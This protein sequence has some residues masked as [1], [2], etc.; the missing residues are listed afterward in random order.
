MNSEQPIELPDG[1]PPVESFDYDLLPPSLRPWIEDVCE[2]MQCPPDFAAVTAIVALGAVI[3]QKITIRPQQRTDWT[4]T[5]NQWGLCIGRP[6]TMK[7]P[8]QQ[9]M[10]SPLDLLESKAKDEY[11]Q[12]MKQHQAKLTEI[13]LRKEAAT[14]VMKKAFRRNPNAETP[15][16]SIQI[17]DPE[18]PCFRRYRII[19]SSVQ[20]LAE[21]HRKAPNG[22][23]VYRDEI[24][25]LLKTLDRDDRA[26][27]RGFYLTGWNGNSPWITD[28][29]GRGMNLRIDSVCLS[30][31]GGTQPAKIQKYAHEAIHGGTGDDGLIQR[32]GLM[33][34]PDIHGEWRNIDREPDHD[35]K[36]RAFK[37]FESLDTLEPA[38]HG[39]QYDHDS[40][41]QPINPPYLRFAP[42]AAELFLEWRTD[43]EN[44]LRNDG[45]HPAMESHLAK[46]RKHIPGLALIL[47]LANGNNGPVSEPPL[48]QALAWGDYLESHAKR[49]YS[50]CTQLEIDAAKA[51]LRLLR[52]KTISSPVSARDIYHMGRHQLSNQDIVKAALELLASR[53]WL[54]GEQKSTGGRPTIVYHAR[55]E[56]FRHE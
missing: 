50:A 20:A 13:K 12:D 25:A 23:L 41:G 28:R 2:R 35:A 5:P 52:N 55:P 31:I 44:R 30:L 1:P 51:I 29:I 39:A 8:A 22:I 48:T 19:D 27:D 45:M 11:D 4:V 46:Y 38:K 36:R 47:H 3:G 6:G 7:T 37:I 40:N 16:C 43:L 33:V 42:D 34:W 21:A 18:E 10:L 24:T 14:E 17:D 15:H 49:V 26:E 54:T 9:A 56:I 53:H 32:F